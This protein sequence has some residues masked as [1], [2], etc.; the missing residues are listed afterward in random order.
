MELT[1]AQGR[2]EYP[3]S[4]ACAPTRPYLEFAARV[5][6]SP[7]KEAF[8]ALKVGDE[9][10]IDGPYG[11]FVLAEESP[12]VLVAGGIGITPLKGMA[13]YAADRRL[14]IDVRLVYSNR[15]EEEIAYRSELEELTR[16]NPRF[17]VRHTLTRLPEGSTWTGRRGRL[18][19]GFLADAARGLSDP[20]Y[21]VCGTW[22][23]VEETVRLLASGG[24]SAD[25]IRYEVFRGY[26]RA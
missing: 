7:W 5:S 15:T 2:I 17:E 10:E 19:G 4:L 3:M 24:I 21:Y 6:T 22:G 26:G 23:M 18:D 25:R 8:A 20:V 16:R 14:P 9:A 13:E 1:T 12:A 11:H